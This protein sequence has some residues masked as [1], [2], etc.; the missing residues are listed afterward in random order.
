M[1]ATVDEL[2]GQEIAGVAFGRNGVD[3]L[4]TEATVRCFG[5]P[6]VTIG[7]STYRFPK[8]G[9]REA[10]CLVIGSTI[11]ALDLAQQQHL[12]F[13]TSNGCRVRIP[14]DADS[15]LHLPVPE[16]PKTIL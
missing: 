14:L 5:P 10:L 8:A 13:T 6:S 3:F 2:L 7:E 16:R 9:S 11:E 1:A 15:D 12:V 4:F